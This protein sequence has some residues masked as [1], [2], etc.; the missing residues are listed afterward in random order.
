[1][2]LLFLKEKRKRREMN[3]HHRKIG[4]LLLKKILTLSL[5]N[6]MSI[7][8]QK[9]RDKTVCPRALREPRFPV[10]GNVPSFSF[11]NL[12]QLCAVMPIQMKWERSQMMK[13]NPYA[14]DLPK[15]TSVWSNRIERRR[16]L[17]VMMFSIL[18]TRWKRIREND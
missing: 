7:K 17:I 10:Y 2:E 18:R 1:M 9:L 13:L 8:G 16:I 6:S 12:V 11:A 5:V 14:G 4:R 3:N 15:A